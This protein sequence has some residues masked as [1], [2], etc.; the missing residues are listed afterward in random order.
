MKI[1]RTFLLVLIWFGVIEGL[2]TL[3]LFFV[4]MPMKYMYDQPELVATAGRIHGGLFIALVALFV[5]GKNAVPL[6][7]K[8]VTY[9]IIGAIFPFGPFIVDVPLYKLLQQKKNDSE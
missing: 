3:F 2:S 6:S 4:A 9:G 7:T 8:L 1:N 5:I